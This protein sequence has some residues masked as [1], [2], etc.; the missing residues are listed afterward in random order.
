MSQQAQPYVLVPL[1][2]QRKNLENRAHGYVADHLEKSEEKHESPIDN[3]Q[4]DETEPVI[5]KPQEPV[6][7][8]PVDPP[9]PPPKKPKPAQASDKPISKS[10]HELA[11]NLSKYKKSKLKKIIDIIDSHGEFRKFDNLGEL[12][13]QAVGTRKKELPNEKQ[14]YELM[15]KLGL[16][17]LISNTAK[18]NKYF[19][20]LNKGQW[21]KI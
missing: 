15:F 8:E 9:S 19:H 5:E 1:H 10:L 12:I 21:Y 17:H 14:F 13:V 4:S 7:T 2:T 11:P 20:L 3:H 6:K 16:G 18:I